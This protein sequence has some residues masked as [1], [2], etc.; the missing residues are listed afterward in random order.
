MEEVRIDKFLWAVRLYKTRSIATEAVKTGRV[1][2]NNK[3]VKPSSTVKVGDTVKVKVNP[4][5]KAFKIKELLKNRVGAKL[6][7][8]YILDVTPPEDVELYQ[9]VLEANRMNRAKG[10]G[11]PTKKDRRDM[12]SFFDDEGLYWDDEND[13]D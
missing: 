3:E 8:D 7:P 6:V 2:L 10:L 1:L 5:F 4:I 11:R 13:D 9:M 12:D